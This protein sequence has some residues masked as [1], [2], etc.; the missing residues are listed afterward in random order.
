MNVKKLVPLY[1]QVILEYSEGFIKQQIAR[2]KPQ[3]GPYVTEQSIRNRLV[4]FD[5]LKT[6]ASR[7][8]LVQV[9]NDAIANGTIAPDTG[10]M[11][12]EEMEMLKKEDPKELDPMQRVALTKYQKDVERIEKLKKNPIEVTFYNWKD[13]EAV[14]DQFPDPAEKKA[15]KQ[16]AKSGSTGAS[17]IYDQNNLEIYLPADGKQ[18]FLLKSSIIKRRSDPNNPNSAKPGEGRSSDPLRWY[19]WCIAANPDGASNL[20][21]NYRFGKYGSDT[22]KSPY[23]VYDEDKPFGDK[24]HF[25]VIQVGQKSPSGRGK[26]FVTSALNDGDSWM[27]WDEIVQLQPKLQG[28]ENLFQFIP[29]THDEEIKIATADARAEDFKNFKNYDAKRAYIMANKKIYAEDYSKLDKILQ[30][31]YVNVR[32]PNQED[33]NKAAMLRKLMLLFQNSDGQRDLTDKITKA[34]EIGRNTPKNDD[35]YL[36]VLV[37]NP[38]MKQSKSEQ[39]YKRWRQLIIDVIKDIGAAKRAAQQQRAAAGN[40]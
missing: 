32:S 3:A 31:L 23:F 7:A 6:G 38:I 28:L 14:V 36:E 1:E 9:L 30:H 21:D 10:R 8:A 4:R 40:A 12:P 2:L 39:T 29:Y 16:A 27:N 15:L 34:K 35:S 24:W 37:D 19:H 26:Y 33:P 22:P 25:M 13:L 18:A 20:W 5:Q 11:S 17:L